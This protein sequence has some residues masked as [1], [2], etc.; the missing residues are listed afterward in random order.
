[1]KPTSLK[2]GGAVS[3]RI[4]SVCRHCLTVR[5]Q[6]HSLKVVLLSATLPPAAKQELYVPMG[7]GDWL[8]IDA[9][10]ARYEFD[11]VVQSYTTSERRQE[12]LEHAVDWVP[13]PLILYTTLVTD[14]NELYRGKRSRAVRGLHYLPVKPTARLEEHCL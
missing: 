14:A 4:S 2:V 6:D 9:R 10:T 8:E 5:Q 13:R 12:A 11:I 1:M 3:D 7:V